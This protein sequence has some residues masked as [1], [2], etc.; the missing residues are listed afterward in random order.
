MNLRVPNEF[1]PRAPANRKLL[2]WIIYPVY[3]TN[4]NVDYLR[5]VRI[6]ENRTYTLAL[7]ETGRETIINSDQVFYRVRVVV[8]CH[9]VNVTAHVFI[10]FSLR[11]YRFTISIT[12]ETVDPR[13]FTN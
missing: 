11:I 8:H 10:T 7:D 3:P 4:E 2:N 13:L 5:T 12:T 1:F 6:R 9:I